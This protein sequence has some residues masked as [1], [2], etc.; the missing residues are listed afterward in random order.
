MVPLVRMSRTPC[1]RLNTSFAMCAARFWIITGRVKVDVPDVDTK[2][3]EKL[4]CC[5]HGAQVSAYHL[6]WS[7]RVALNFR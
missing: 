4:E 7:L 3:V 6:L 5:I 1:N 2:L